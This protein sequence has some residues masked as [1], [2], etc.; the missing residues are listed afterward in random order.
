MEPG[1][2][3]LIHISD[4]KTDTRDT[5]PGDILKK[6]QS[7][8]VQINSIDKEKKRISLKPVSSTLEDEDSKKYMEPESDTYNP[9]AALL[10][11]KTKK[12]KKK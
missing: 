12:S 9:F 4:L 7:I 3:G 11:D 2:D 5:N 6:G 10:K 1:L 8:T